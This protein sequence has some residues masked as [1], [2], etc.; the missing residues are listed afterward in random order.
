MVIGST[1]TLIY[2]R[3]ERSMKLNYVLL[4][5]NLNVRICGLSV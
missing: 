2:K 3:F 4:V 1:K 5:I